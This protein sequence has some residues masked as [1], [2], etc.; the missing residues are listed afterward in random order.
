MRYFFVT[1]LM[2]LGIIFVRCEKDSTSSTALPKTGTLR[3]YLTDAPSLAQF[4]SVKIKFSQV[5]AHLDSAWI[6]V[7]G[8][9]IT[10]NLLEL[11]NGNTIVFGSSDVPAGKYTQ[12]RIIIDDAWVVIDGVRKPMDVPSGA[13]TGLKLGPQFTVM[14]GS[15]YEIVVDF[16]V[17]RSVVI[18]G[19]PH[20]P[21][22]KLKPHLRVMPM[23]VSGSISGIVTNPDSLPTAWAIQDADTITSTIV[24]PISGF[25][26]LGF[27]PAGFYTVSIRDTLD[28][29]ADVDSVEVIAGTDKNLGS[30]TLF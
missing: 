13:K 30:I 10:V 28:K 26:R 11:I 21:G 25:F 1:F 24:D 4:D 14:E 3:I 19:P 15:T 5:S 27:L 17:N 18:T 6:T 16:D 29:S 2:L 8:D 12:I 20:N 22:F 9:P 7:Q 23:A